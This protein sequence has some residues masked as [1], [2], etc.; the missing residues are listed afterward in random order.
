M[1]CNVFRE[2]LNSY[3]DETLEEDRRQSFQRHLRECAS[4]RESALSKDP[5]L[6]FAAA[7][8]PVVSQTDVEACAVAVTARIRQQRL[9]HRLQR[10]RRPWLA[11]AAAIVIMIAGGLIWKVML[12]DVGGSAAPGIEAFAEGDAQTVPPTVEV[13]MA[14]EDVRVYQ[15][16]ADDD[17]NTAV[18]FIVNPAMEL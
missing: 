13:E 3:L 4:C 9:A 14:G 2:L 18:Y 17:D 12:G 5:S 6:L 15:F 10:R 1:D 7:P 11:A 8:E 16:A